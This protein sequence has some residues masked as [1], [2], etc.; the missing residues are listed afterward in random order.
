MLFSL[1]HL[2]LS[3]IYTFSLKPKKIPLLLISY[4]WNPEYFFGFLCV[5]LCSSLHLFVI[6]WN[7]WQW[8][9]KLSKEKGLSSWLDL[10]L[11][12]EGSHACASR[13]RFKVFWLTKPR[14][15]WKQEHMRIVSWDKYVMLDCSAISFC[16]PFL[17]IS[18][19]TQY[20]RIAETD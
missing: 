7:T 8:H 2:V 4:L 9:S 17:F 1:K 14:V 18:V 19:N 3:I 15:L 13:K 11:W 10:E 16:A 12:Q 5:T 20:T 6:L